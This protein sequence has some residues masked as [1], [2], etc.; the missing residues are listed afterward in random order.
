MFLFIIINTNHRVKMCL[1]SLNPVL[2]FEWP[3]VL[4]QWPMLHLETLSLT[5]KLESP[6]H[7]GARR[8]GHG[9]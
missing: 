4:G 1:V 3:Q 7:L 6:S 9:L 8:A 5:G 2:L